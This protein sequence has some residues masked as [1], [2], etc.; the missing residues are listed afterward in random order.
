M[1]AVGRH[2]KSWFRLLH[3]QLVWLEPEG[4]GVLSSNSCLCVD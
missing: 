2:L 3:L 4:M 1:I